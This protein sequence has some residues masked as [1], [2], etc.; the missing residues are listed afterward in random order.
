[1][2]GKG[3]INLIL[4]TERLAL[5]EWRPDDAEA[6]F[7]LMGDAEVMRYVDVGK[8]WEDVGRVRDWI[9][10]LNESYRTRGFSRWA[11]VEREGGRAVGSCG[12]ARLP[13]S[14]ETDFG[15]MFRRDCWGRGYASEI[16]A[17]TLRHGFERYGFGEVVASIAPENAAS[18]RVLLKLGFVYRG[19][20]VMPGEDEES[21]IYAAVNPAG[22]GA[23][24]RAAEPE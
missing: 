17:A 8:P 2:T 15:Y 16:T 10:R 18:R 5:R 22:A 1:M 19:N 11:V 7:E 4:E 24:A 23:A 6:L 21:E 3:A 14:G 13:W 9:T 20:T 12:F